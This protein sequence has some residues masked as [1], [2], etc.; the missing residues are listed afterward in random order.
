MVDRESWMVRGKQRNFHRR[1][2]EDAEE[3]RVGLG[4][5]AG[6]GKAFLCSMFWEAGTREMGGERREIFFDP[7]SKRG[8]RRGAYLFEDK[9][10]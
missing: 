5:A 7:R 8:F 10:Q 2:A 6:E 9:V 3:R 4:V 1:G